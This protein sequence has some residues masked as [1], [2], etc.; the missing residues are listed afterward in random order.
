[1]YQSKPL[2]ASKQGIGKDL[3]KLSVHAQALK[4]HGSHLKRNSNSIRPKP[5]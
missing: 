4:Y 2:T 1:M 5:E 3:H